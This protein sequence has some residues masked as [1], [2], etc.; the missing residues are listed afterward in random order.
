[1]AYRRT[2][3]MAF[4]LLSA[5]TLAGNWNGLQCC[6]RRAFNEATTWN[7]RGY[8]GNGEHTDGFR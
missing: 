5:A 4:A 3:P 1:M 6:V 7:N 8:R 2:F